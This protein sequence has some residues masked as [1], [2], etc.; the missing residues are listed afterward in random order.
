MLTGR[1]KKQRYKTWICPWVWAH[2][3][4]PS[5]RHSPVEEIIFSSPGPLPVATMTGHDNISETASCDASVIVLSCQSLTP[6][7]ASLI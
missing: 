2:A 3:V 5:F 7:W 6:S 1:W 4:S